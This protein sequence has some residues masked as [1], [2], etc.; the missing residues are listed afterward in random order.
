V[1]VRNPVRVDPR[2]TSA[3]IAGPNDAGK[4][5][6]F[7][8]TAGI[9]EHGSGRIVRPGLDAMLFLPERPYLRPGTLRDALLPP[10]RERAI[11]D[12]QIATLLRDLHVDGILER[13]GGLDVE[14]DWDDVLSLTEQKLLSVARVVPRCADLCLPRATARVAGCRTGRSNHEAVSG[15]I[16]HVSHARRRRRALERP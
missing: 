16:D 6:L 10:G 2:G 12:E 3:L 4:V 1:L 5:A 14:R 9:W 7:R 13:V 8:A 15:A 11:G